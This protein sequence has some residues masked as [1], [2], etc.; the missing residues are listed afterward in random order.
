MSPSTLQSQVCTGT[1]VGSMISISSTSLEAIQDASTPSGE[2]TISPILCSFPRADA[3]PFEAG[4]LRAT[5]WLQAV[6]I[7]I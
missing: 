6:M 7:S 3:S 4:H 5:S 2:S 1:E